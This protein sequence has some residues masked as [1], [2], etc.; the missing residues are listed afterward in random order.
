MVN[1]TFRGRARG[2]GRLD[3]E[4]DA[5]RGTRQTWKSREIGKCYFGQD[6]PRIAKWAKVKNENN[7]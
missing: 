3:G 5:V 2:A 7:A 1:G 4:V 6:N